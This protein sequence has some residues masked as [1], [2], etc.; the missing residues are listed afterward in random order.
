MN[1]NVYE[2]LVDWWNYHD[3]KNTE[4]L[5]GVRGDMCQ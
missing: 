4:E 2:A 3:S 1:E 5:G